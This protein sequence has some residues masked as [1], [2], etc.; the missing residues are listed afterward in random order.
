MDNALPLVAH[1]DLASRVKALEEDGYV[2]LPQIIEIEEAVHGID[3]HI[4]GMTAWVPKK[5]SVNL[6]MW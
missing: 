2:Y 3:C 6:A 5:F 1:P 4:I